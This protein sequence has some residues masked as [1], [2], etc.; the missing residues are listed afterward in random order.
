MINNYK[1]FFEFFDGQLVK[2]ESDRFKLFKLMLTS[3]ISAFGLF[4]TISGMCNIYGFILLEIGMLWNF[5]T[6]LNKFSALVLSVIVAM[7]YFIFA[8]EFAVYANGLIYFGCYLTLQL[9]ASTKNYDEGDFIQIK[10]KI[11][12]FNK[13]L[14]VIF[15]SCVFIFL[16]LFDTTTGSR[17]IVLDSLSAAL[18][19]CSALLRNERYVEYYVFRFFALATSITLWIIVWVEYNS[20][21]VIPILLMY[22][23]YL[24]F[25]A[26]S[27]ITQYK[28][29]KNEYMLQVEK[30][31]EMQRQNKIA[32]KEQEYAKIK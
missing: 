11:T 19:V 2:P 18:L 32:E 16:F 12:D 7:L 14:L 28:T 17:F 13:V 23:S 6:K 31:E 27:C 9:I 20:A 29:Y 8:A 15:F 5:Y 3:I 1:F 21:L 26:V 30:Y 22:F 24:I 25:D 4:F 10:K